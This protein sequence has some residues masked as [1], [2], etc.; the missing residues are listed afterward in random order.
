[1]TATAGHNSGISEKD[2]RVLFFIHRNEHV[3][4][5]EAKKAADAALRNHGKQVKADL[6]E[7]GMRQIKLYEELRTPE[8][9]AKFKA[10]CAAEAQAAIWAGL[11]VNTQA[12]MFSDLAPL[13]ERAFRDGEEA[14]LRG[15]TY[16]NPYDQNSHHGREFERGWKSGQAELFEGIKK[17]EAEASTDEHISGADPFE[18]AA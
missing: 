6:G 3:R 16:S 15:D 8:G 5:M 11:P 4:L 1:M 9:E 17:K 12:D 10:Q 18:D 14:G 7:N 13:D 2:Q